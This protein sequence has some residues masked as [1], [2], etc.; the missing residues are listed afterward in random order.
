MFDSARIQL[1]IVYHF[2]NSRSPGPP[3]RISDYR[4]AGFWTL[5]RAHFM[6]HGSV[7]GDRKSRCTLD[8]SVSTG[9]SLAQISAEIPESKWDA[10]VS[11]LRPL[12][13]IFFST[14]FGRHAG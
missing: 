3:G 14:G 5:E 4:G 7:S 10:S 1:R 9:T 8:N 11:P 2:I 6:G 12:P 13:V